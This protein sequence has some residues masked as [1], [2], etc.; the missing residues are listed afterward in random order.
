ME[1]ILSLDVGTTVVKSVLFNLSGQELFVSEVSLTLITGD[2]GKAEQDP[3][4]L[5]R[6]VLNV[7]SRAAGFSRSKGGVIISLALA[8]QGGSLLPLDKDENPRG[9]IILWMD[10][11]AAP[12]V[13]RWRRDGTASYIRSRCGWSPESGLPLPQICRIR[14]DD[15]DF[16]RETSCWVS[17]H[18]FLLGRMVGK[19][20]SNP[21]V[22]VE[23]LLTG[24][25]GRTW[26]EQLCELAGINKEAL[27]RIETSAS[28]VGTI[29]EALAEASSLPAGLELTNG[30]QDHSC[31]ALAGGLLKEGGVMLACG[32]AWVLNAITGSSDPSRYP[33]GV[34][35]TPHV[36]EGFWTAGRF[37]GA[38][39]GNLEYLIREFGKPEEPGID[40][41]DSRN[42]TY[43]DLERLMEAPDE[44]LDGFFESTGLIFVPPD[45]SIYRSDLSRRAGFAGMGRNTRWHHLAAAVMESASFEV[46]AALDSLGGGRKELLMVGGGGRSR[47][48]R[49]HIADIS[50][51][52]VLTPRYSHGPALGAA[53]TAL[54]AQ[55]LY[56][57]YAEILDSFSPGTDTTV[58]NL[59]RR[60]SL[61]RRR[62]RYREYLLHLPV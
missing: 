30:G 61:L 28:I 7:L 56:P 6:A 39:G 14:E 52:K 54:Y 29:T 24:P 34:N 20:I 48:W 26:D 19:R 21:S 49:Q 18:D 27:S 60:G 8:S 10:Q 9:N 12:L 47:W 25:D 59:E 17:V 57:S 62:E 33:E 51:L 11:R 41:E 4:E 50:G 2:D 36:A 46:S 44:K 37:L 42:R 15:P 32:T 53:M 22:A 40:A 43:Q 5:W 38:L 45:G 31:E 55:G 35:L 16:F 13:D 3:E 23:M 1:I 58:P